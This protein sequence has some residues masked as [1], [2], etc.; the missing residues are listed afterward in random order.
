MITSRE[1]N[2]EHEYRIDLAELIEREKAIYRDTAITYGEYLLPNLWVNRNTGTRA[3][4]ELSFHDG[5]NYR[6]MYTHFYERG[7]QLDETEAYVIYQEAIETAILEPLIPFN[8]TMC[9]LEDE[10]VGNK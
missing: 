3:Y 2:T 7:E 8:L 4:Y 5:K 10:Y 6:M 9:H 1:L